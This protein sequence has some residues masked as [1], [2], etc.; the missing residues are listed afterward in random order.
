MV[1]GLEKLQMLECESCQVGKHVCSSFPQE[2]EKKNGPSQV[3]SF[4]FR[5]FVTFIDEYSQCTRILIRMPSSSLD[6][7][8][9]HFIIFPKEPLFHIPL[10]GFGCT[11]LFMMFLKVCI[12]YLLEPSNVFLVFKKGIVI[13]ELPLNEE[14][15]E[16]CPTLSITSMTDPSDE[17]SSSPIVFDL[18]ETS[19]YLQFSKLSSFISFIFFFCVFLVFYSNSK[20]ISMKWREAMIDEM[21]DLEHSGTWEL[22]SL[23]LR[24][25][26][27]SCRW[28]YVIK[29]GPN[30]KVYC[31][32]ARLVAKGYTHIYG[33]DYGNT[34][35][36]MTKISSIHLF[37][38][39]VAIC[40]WPL[41]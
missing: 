2:I 18:L 31:H 17:N 20:K 27:A 13:V 12:S 21:Q 14:P 4:G 8:I 7:E 32:K 38:V 28:V 9:R 29:V 16:S 24:K 19:S 3:S 36:P 6:N 23:P 37:L 10:L 26:S 35:S 25:T 40:H 33:L 39:M 22:V 1:L 34:F 5:Y 11:C 30:G 15:S 41:H